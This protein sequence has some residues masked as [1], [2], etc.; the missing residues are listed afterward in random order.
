M[1]DDIKFNLNYFDGGHTHHVLNKRGYKEIKLNQ[2][3]QLKRKFINWCKTN[4]LPELL[5]RVKDLDKGKERKDIILLVPPNYGPSEEYHLLG[6]SSFSKRYTEEMNSRI[7]TTGYMYSGW[8][9]SIK[10]E[11]KK[12]LSVPFRLYVGEK[13]KVKGYFR[14][15]DFW[16]D[17]EEDK[18][19]E[20]TLN[21]ENWRDHFRDDEPTIDPTQWNSTHEEMWKTRT[22]F[23]YDKVERFSEEKDLSEFEN[24]EGETPQFYQK[25]FDVICEKKEEG[26]KMDKDMNIIGVVAKV[27]WSHNRWKGFDEEGYRKR[28]NYNY[29][30]VRISG[31]AHE[32]WGF[33]EDFDKD[34]Y[35]GHVAM[36]ERTPKKKFKDALI[37][38][39]SYNINNREFYLVGFFGNAKFT[40]EK[41]KTETKMKKL[42]SEDCID[43]LPQIADK[44]DQEDWK[45]AA[46]RMRDFIK[47][48][49]KYDGNIK[50]PKKFSTV[51]EEEA[52]IKIDPQE[53][54]TVGRL[55]QAPYMYIGHTETVPPENVHK[56]LLKAKERHETILKNTQDVNKEEEIEEIIEKIDRVVDKYFSEVERTA[57][58]I[59]YY[60]EVSAAPWQGPIGKI[61]ET[62]VDSKYKMMQELTPGDVVIHYRPSRVRKYPQRFVGYS[63]VKKSAK[64]FSRDELVQFLKNRDIL[65]EKYREF[66]EEGVLSYDKA[67]IVELKDFKE[68]KN[69]KKPS[70]HTV[71]DQLGFKVTEGY[72]HS[73]DKE[74]AEGII[75][76]SDLKEPNERK[77]K[78]KD[79]KQ[80]L[81][82]EIERKF[83]INGLF[84][85]EGERETLEKQITTAI[86]NRKHIILIGAPGTGKSKL[87]KEICEF[88]VGNKNY[89][90]ST[91]TSDWSTFDTIGG[92]H[93]DKEGKLNFKSGIFLRCFR[94][95]E[96]LNP[97]DRWLIIDEIN[98]ADI[99]K[100]FGSLFSALTGDTITLP[101][102]VADEQ[103]EVVGDP[104]DDDEIQG[105][106]FIIHPDWRIIATMNTYDKAS[107][108]EMSYA[109]MRRFAF[110]PVD[111]PNE[112]DEDLIREYLDIW[113]LERE[114]N[115]EL[116][117]KVT[118]L[119]KT[120]NNSRKIGP[121]IIKDIY[122]YLTEEDDLTSA[123][124]MYV[125]PQFEGLPEDKICT[126]VD[127]LDIIEAKDE[128]IDFCVDFF[129]IAREKFK[130]SS[131]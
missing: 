32:W 114:E 100:A 28:E 115:A 1:D 78:W 53:D 27:A 96:T 111:V 22:I 108:Y 70:Y 99:D 92:Y 125:L 24:I 71:K 43:S 12:H 77:E 38:V 21:D 130:K 123:V 5:E 127:E 37:P 66:A 124:I 46:E 49:I 20:K 17:I 72:L 36:S 112:I 109:F 57:G 79:K 107:L 63:K 10:E 25:G 58:P 84:F 129:G 76:L 131:E 4:D 88:Y 101:F 55:G 126:F 128:L 52:Y 80:D 74:I 83:T 89:I 11:K 59:N 104:N 23:K 7:E 98:R 122:E 18:D 26:R 73:L 61:L 69:E 103:I 48:K 120:I 19:L 86:R 110:V 2:D 105:N 87:A 16:T 106:K 121:A 6:A 60:L 85:P 97:E 65:S 90:M 47:N 3:P 41:Y 29:K 64:T 35:Y 113:H 93:P 50:A 67:W 13:K 91:A 116:V 118:K 75:N 40:G 14:V 42:L 117:D 81:G 45:D 31:H 34:Y 9:Y 119:W 94:D 39:I 30:F 51:F 56:L 82:Y 44:F 15:V 102:E 33:Y 95:S 62:G 8:N 54:L 68:F